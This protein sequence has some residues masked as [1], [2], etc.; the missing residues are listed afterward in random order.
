MACDLWEACNG[1]RS[2]NDLISVMFALIL[3][4]SDAHRY[5]AVRAHMYC[6]RDFGVKVGRPS[7]KPSATR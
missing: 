5:A 7:N 6:V 3:V 2:G 1:N 4:Q